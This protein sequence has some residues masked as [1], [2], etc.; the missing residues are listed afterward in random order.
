MCTDRSRLYAT[1]SRGLYVARACHVHR[2]SDC[3]RR[4]N[5]HF[6][7]STN[8]HATLCMDALMAVCRHALANYNLC[9]L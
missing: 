8:P 4:S 3:P 6:M 9:T 2:V 7:F 1:C 5:L